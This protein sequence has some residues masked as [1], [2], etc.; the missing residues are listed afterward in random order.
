MMRR[1]LAQPTEPGRSSS[2]GARGWSAEDWTR[3]QSQA[4][5]LIEESVRPALEVY[6][7]FLEEQ[8]PP[9]SRGPESAGPIALLEGEVCYRGTVLQHSSSPAPR[10]STTGLSALRQ[11]H[12]EF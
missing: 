1:Q 12:Q 5:S 6:T 11:V 4:F 3:V 2:R 8:L 10:R 7:D 9:A